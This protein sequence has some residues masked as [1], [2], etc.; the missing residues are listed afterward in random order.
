[1]THQGEGH[2]HKKIFCSAVPKKHF[3]SPKVRASG[4]GECWIFSVTSC[5]LHRNSHIEDGHKVM[6]W[7]GT[8]KKCEV[9]DDIKRQMWE[10]ANQESEGKRLIWGKSHLKPVFLYFLKKYSPHQEKLEWETKG[11]IEGLITG[12]ATWDQVRRKGA[13]K[14][15]PSAFLK[16]SFTPKWEWGQERTAAIGQI[17]P[18]PVPL[19]LDDTEQK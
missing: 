12:A 16:L 3:I 11:F 13:V 6:I 18:T 10:W 9:D 7:Q 19:V 4:S 1:M 2:S 15:T 8:G 17:S 14:K 5:C